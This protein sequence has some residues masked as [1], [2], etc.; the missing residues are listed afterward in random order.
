MT[1][2]VNCLAI[3]PKISEFIIDL[4][5]VL[6]SRASDSCDLACVCAS[7]SKL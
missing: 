6:Q 1:K 2:V 4:F 7:A 5:E 3:M